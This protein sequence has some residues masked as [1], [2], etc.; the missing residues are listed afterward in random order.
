MIGV[1]L[2]DFECLFEIDARKIV[3]SALRTR[4]LYPPGTFRLRNRGMILSQLEAR[5]TSAKVVV[6][7]GASEI[8]ECSWIRVEALLLHSLLGSDITEDLQGKPKPKRSQ[9]NTICHARWAN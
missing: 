3:R 4:R 8:C 6:P 2:E 9:V 1:F 5:L 7:D